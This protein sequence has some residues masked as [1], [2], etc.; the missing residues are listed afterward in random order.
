MKKTKIVITAGHNWSYF[1]WF[2]LGFSQLQGAVQVKY[3]LPLFSRLLTFIPND[4][5]C[6]VINRLE[7]YSPEKG[8]CNMDGYMLFPD[9]TRK[10]FTIDCADSP[11][12]YDEQRLKTVDVYFKIQCPRNL[13][14]PGFWLT[15]DILVPWSD[16]AHVDETLNSL[17]DRGARRVLQNFGAYTGKIKPLMLGPRRLSRSLTP[18]ALEKA[19]QNYI[20][21]SRTDKSGRVMCYFGNAS[22]PEPETEVVAIDWNWEKDIMAY[23]QGRGSHPNEKRAA[24][25]DHIQTADSEGS[26]DVRIISRS[27]SDSGEGKD[28]SKVIPLKEFCAH[29]AKF[30]YNVNVSGYRLSIPNRFIESFMVGTAIFTD[31]LAVKWYK[32]FDAHEV[33][34]TVPMGYLPMEKVDWQK[35]EQD[36][37]TLP[38][39]DPEKILASFHEKWRP[40]VVAKYIIDT[41]REA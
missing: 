13:D 36:V 4:S 6:G 8:S 38:K 40:D 7:R 5:V 33:I 23:L 17:T 26:C 10:T 15:D 12:L 1:E 37:K 41:V 21:D 14:A 30:Q 18:K 11:F 31:K 27:H 16:Y 2:L 25:A 20:K 3:K 19:Y 34:E 22:G 28:E 24:I 9:G 35:F 39:S 29:I 32:P